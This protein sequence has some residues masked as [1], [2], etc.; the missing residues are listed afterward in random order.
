MA[1]R[2]VAAGIPDEVLAAAALERLLARE[3]AGPAVDPWDIPDGWRIGGH[4]WTQIQIEGTKVWVR[5]LPSAGAEVVVGGGEPVAARAE[6]GDGGLIVSYDGRTRRYSRARQDGIVWLGRD[7]RTWSL[8]EE[9]AGPS[10]AG[11]EGG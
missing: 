1:D 8:T 11:R 4:A 9:Q 7:G 2:A 5:G 10:R 3:P 6:F